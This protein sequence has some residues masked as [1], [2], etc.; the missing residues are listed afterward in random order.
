MTLCSS[1]PASLSCAGGLVYDRSGLTGERQHLSSGCDTNTYSLMRDKSVDLAGSGD[2]AVL[3]QQIR[4]SI[5]VH[6]L[7]M[8]H[9]W[10]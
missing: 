10:L 6:I 3:T 1:I 2:S 5:A 9:G 7:T 4:F 8:L